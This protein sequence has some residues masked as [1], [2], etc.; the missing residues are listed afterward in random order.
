MVLK[1]YDHNVVC[2]VLLL[3]FSQA[4]KLIDKLQK[5]PF[6]LQTIF[7]TCWEKETDV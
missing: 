5:F 1:I 2:I 4:S 7:A 6:L 3:R